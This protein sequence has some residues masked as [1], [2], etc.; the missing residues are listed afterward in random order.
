MSEVDFNTIMKE[1]KISNFKDILQPHQEPAKTPGGKPQY[2]RSGNDLA[3]AVSASDKDARTQMSMFAFPGITGLVSIGEGSS[4]PELP[5]R[6]PNW[7]GDLLFH[8]SYSADD[9]GWGC[10]VSD[11]DGVPIQGVRDAELE[12]A[13]HDAVAAFSWEYETPCVPPLITED[14]HTRTQGWSEPLQRKQ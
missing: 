2:F 5:E 6:E 12:R 3:V 4:F 14:S 1:L 8:A 11:A 9:E 10:L 13:A 7:E